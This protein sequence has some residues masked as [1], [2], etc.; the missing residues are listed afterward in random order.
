VA[1]EIVLTTNLNYTNP[2]FNIA[3]DQLVTSGQ[4]FTITG[5]NKLHETMTVPTTSGGT[6]IPLGGLSTLGWYSIKN[7]DPTNYVQ[8]MTAVSG[9]VINQCPPRG[10]ITGY[11]PASITAP[12]LIA[13]TAG[14]SVEMLILE[15]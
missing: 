5:S 6:A 4:Q 14:C 13:H 9:T 8:L 2:A 7:N 11:F 1:N 12:A 15:I 3:T 10:Q